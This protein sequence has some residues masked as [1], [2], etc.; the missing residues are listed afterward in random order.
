MLGT[1]NSSEK[2]NLKE[3][4]QPVVHAYNA[5]TQKS[6]GFSPNYLHFGWHPRLAI[7]AFLGLEDPKAKKQSRA[8]YVDKIKRRVEFAYKK[9]AEMSIKS[10]NKHKGYYD[11]KIRHSTLE[12]GDSILLKMS[13]LT[14]S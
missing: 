10:S 6:T 8:S 4:V 11:S 1:L 9:A 14:G 5:T 7:D 3:F 13:L 12:I 2:A